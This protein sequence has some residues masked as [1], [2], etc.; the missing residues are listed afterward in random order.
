VVRFP[1]T[2]ELVVLRTVC[3]WPIIIALMTMKTSVEMSVMVLKVRFVGESVR[4]DVIV[5]GAVT[6]GG[7][8]I[9]R[10]G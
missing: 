7:G 8:G 9:L 2:V 1:K 3:V 6:R 4:M 10:C 5:E